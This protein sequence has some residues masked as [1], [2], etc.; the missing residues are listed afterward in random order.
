MAVFFTVHDPTTLN[1]QGNDVGTQYRSG[2]YYVDAAQK[3]R[4]ED[5]VR[6]EAVKYWSDPIVTEIEQ[7]DVFYPAEDYHQDYYKKNPLRYK[8]YRINSGRAGYLEK[9]WKDLI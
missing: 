6:N 3:Q 4:A 8:M 5:F 7:L 1:R 2:I 9:T